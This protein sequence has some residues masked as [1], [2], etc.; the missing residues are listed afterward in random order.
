MYTTEQIKRVFARKKYK[1]FENGDYNL[2][3]ILVRKDDVFTDKFTDLLLLV[4]KEKGQFVIKEFNAT[5]KAGRYGVQNPI[6]V[7]GITG[8]A[9]LKEGQYLGAYQFV[10]SSANKWKAPYF[11]QIKPITV[12]RDADKD[13]FI[14]RVKEQT[15]I[16]GIQGHQMG[17]GNVIYNWSIGCWG[18][19]L[20]QWRQITAIA[21]KSAAIYGDK[22][23]ITLI[24]QN[25]L[26]A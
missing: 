8:V 26:F 14:D 13:G 6:T 10:N 9:V 19:P 15:G 17:A 21:Q 2:N 12:Y 3:I 18:T 25:E 7:N 24:S 11:K 20:K 4:Y 1:F 22:F 23:T 16:F 5:T